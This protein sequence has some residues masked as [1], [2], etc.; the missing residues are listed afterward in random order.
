MKILSEKYLAKDISACFEF[1]IISK[2][3]CEK[4]ANWNV[5]C[6]VKKSES[7]KY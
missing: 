4:R 1:D 2:K 6:G 5:L 7:L 3:L